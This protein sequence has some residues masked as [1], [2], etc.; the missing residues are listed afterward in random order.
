[1][2]DRRLVRRAGGAIRPVQAVA[3]DRLHRSVCP[4]AN[5]HAALASGLQPLGPVAADQA[6]DAEASAEPLLGMR[7]GGQDALDERDGGRADRLG[8][9]Q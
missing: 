9:A 8:L 7:L 4:G 5:V 6:Q 2:L 1:M 3:Q